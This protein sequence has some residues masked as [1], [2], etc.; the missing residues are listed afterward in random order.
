SEVY[1]TALEAQLRERI[2]VDFAE[3]PSEDRSKRPVREI[4]GLDPRLAERWSSRNAAIVVR[5]A[6][7]AREFQA[8]H[9]REPTAIEAIR[10]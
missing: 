5:T 1:N 7:L 4:V 9:H 8:E 2:G 10:L 6:E 3:R